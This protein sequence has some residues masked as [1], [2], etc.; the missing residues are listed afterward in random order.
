M[1]IVLRNAIEN[2]ERRKK[3]KDTAFAENFGSANYANINKEY[4]FK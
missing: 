3:C 1:L 4:G 2:N